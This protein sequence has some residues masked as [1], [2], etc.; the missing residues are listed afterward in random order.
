MIHGWGGDYS[1][2]PKQSVKEELDGYQMR[3]AYDKT[4]D[5]IAVDERIGKLIY[6]ADID[7]YI[8]LFPNN[9][10]DHKI[11][12]V[13][14]PITQDLRVIKHIKCEDDDSRYDFTLKLTEGADYDLP[15]NLNYVKSDG[16]RG[17]VAVSDT[18]DFSL[19][20]EESVTFISIPQGTGY[21]IKELTP[22]NGWVLGSYDNAVG[23][24]TGGD[25]SYIE[26]YC[27]ATA[28]QRAAMRWTKDD[29][30]Y[31]A[32]TSIP[33]SASAI[34]DGVSVSYGSATISQRTDFNVLWSEDGV[35]YYYDNSHTPDDA[36]AEL[37]CTDAAVTNLKLQSL[38]L[39]KEV[40]G[41]TGD[42]GSKWDFTLHI[43]CLKGMTVTAKL[44]GND[45]TLEFDGN[46]TAAVRMGHNDLLIIDSLPC[47]SEYTITENTDP[48]YTQG[49]SINGSDMI[50]G[51]S[52]GKQAINGD[53][54]IKFTN[55]SA[56][57]PPTGLFTS[58]A[59]WLIM[60]MIAAALLWLFNRMRSVDTLDS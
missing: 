10:Y 32:G 27:N 9:N 51:N 12:V 24:L 31:N 52:T 43:P 8:Y 44:N 7:A 35:N 11:H 41:P 16:T 26:Q 6:R 59:P 28:T 57:S 56:V 47:S 53:T 34:F 2:H 49:Y 13:W 20:A 45:K 40:T 18:I 17:T 38:T 23:T 25:S 15:Q 29:T 39:K 19:K 14:K 36:T 58:S 50:P 42:L 60:L 30:V 55:D 5:D 3:A 1:C 21:E 37:A 46:G 4:V 48:L 54:I 22:P 33:L